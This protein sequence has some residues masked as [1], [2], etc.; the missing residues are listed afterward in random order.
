MDKNRG[1]N[2]MQLI[3]L[4]SCLV[5]QLRMRQDFAILHYTPHLTSLFLELFIQSP[6]D[7]HL[8]GLT[9]A[10]LPRLRLLRLK[11]MMYEQEWPILVP[12]AFFAC[13]SPELEEFEVRFVFD[14]GKFEEFQEWTEEDLYAEADL[15]EIRARLLPNV[16]I[17]PEQGQEQEQQEQLLLPPIPRRQEPLLKLTSFYVSS[18]DSLSES[19]V[20]AIFDHCPNC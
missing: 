9:L 6:V 15:V 12:V 13:S 11:A 20:D 7:I 2:N 4:D 3:Y 16:A 5:V 8:L 18:M 10:G 1:D 14:D 19:E 17:E